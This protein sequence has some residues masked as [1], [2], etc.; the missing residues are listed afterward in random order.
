MERRLIPLS[1]KE[2]SKIKVDKIDTVIYIGSDFVKRYAY[3]RLG[4][5]LKG[6]IVIVSID[7]LT[8]VTSNPRD[9]GYSDF[10]KI[11]DAIEIAK[12]NCDK[13]KIYLVDNSEGE[14]AKK[15]FMLYEF[16]ASVYDKAVLGL[17]FN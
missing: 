12:F 5:L 9:K 7:N 2:F 16:Q 1:K 6:N 14:I 11:V 15:V 4:G 8:Q 10:K 3:E 17:A 13:C